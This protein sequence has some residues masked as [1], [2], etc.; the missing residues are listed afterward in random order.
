MITGHVI[1]LARRPD[2]WKRIKEHWADIK[3]V[4][5]E[6]FEA[7]TGNPTY[8]ALIKSQK[9]IVQKAKDDNEPYV[10]IM[11][12]DA[13][14]EADFDNRFTAILEWLQTHDN[15]DMFYGGHTFSE[16]T[17]IID[18]DLKLISG[19]WFT[20]HFIIIKN[21]VYD[22]FLNWEPNEPC[23]VYFRNLDIIRVATIP[24][25]SRQMI[26]YSDLQYNMADYKR[27]FDDSDNLL[28]RKFNEDPKKSKSN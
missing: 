11:E 27:H 3:T 25:L 5:L 22:R 7:Y 2:R 10:L 18:E 6:R 8:I 23:D 15:W 4:K 13:T 14:H 24:T 9:T 1:N 17:G 12:D 26:S 28:T 19:S 20:C 21:T 16:Y